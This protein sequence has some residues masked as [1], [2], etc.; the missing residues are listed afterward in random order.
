MRWNS[1]SHAV[2]VVSG[3]RRCLREAE[4]GRFASGNAGVHQLV[5]RIAARPPDI[6]GVIDLVADRKGSNLR[7][8]RLDHAGCVVTQDLRRLQRL[9]LG[10]AYLRIDRVHRDRLHPHQ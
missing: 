4:R 7:A 3:Q 5:L 8:D 9:R 1:S 6:A 2:R 10:R